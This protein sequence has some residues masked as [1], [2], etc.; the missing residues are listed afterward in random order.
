MYYNVYAGN[1]H[2][3]MVIAENEQHAI[4]QVTAKFGIATNYTRDAIYGYKAVRA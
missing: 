3:D 2:M 1:I 4:D